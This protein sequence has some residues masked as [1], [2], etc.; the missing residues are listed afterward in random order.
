MNYRQIQEALWRW[1]GFPT[2]DGRQDNLLQEIREA[3]NNTHHDV[4]LSTP[5]WWFNIQKWTVSA[6]AGTSYYTVSDWLR[7]PTRIWVEG[8]TAGPLDFLTPEEVDRQGLRSTSQT[9]TGDS[10]R[11]YTMKEMRRDPLYTVVGNTVVGNTTFTRTSGDLLVDAMVGLRVRVN[12]EPVDYKVESINAVANTYVVDKAYV[13][14]LSL[15][16]GTTGAGSNTTGG[17]MEFSPGPVWQ[18]EIMPVPSESKSIYVWGNARERYLTAD[19]DVPE[20]PEG[21]QEVMTIG[22]K[23]RLANSLRRPME[24]QQALAGEFAHYI[25]K[26]RKVDMPVGGAKQLH[27]ESAFK[28]RPPLRTMWN[29][30]NDVF[31]WRGR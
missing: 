5:F 15:S 21:W 23:R 18:L 1:A 17:T 13:P 31:P 2:A 4:F 28:T 26:M 12:G 10:I 3:I 7:L 16:E 24:E 29:R 8:D 25:N 14:M 9:Q 19:T 11:T 22:S 30:P 6:I 27:Y 20:I